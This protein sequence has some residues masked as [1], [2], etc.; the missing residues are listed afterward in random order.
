[1]DKNEYKPFLVNV[2]IDLCQ[3]FSGAAK[4]FYGQFVLDEMKNYTNVNLSKCPIKPGL[5]YLN[6]YTLNA[7]MLRNMPVPLGLFRL[8]VTFF[9]KEKSGLK[10]SSKFEFF[11]QVYNIIKKMIKL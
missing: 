8:D 7:R 10:Y 5:I 2:T 11:V 1:M 6:N 4:I 3:L 9:Q